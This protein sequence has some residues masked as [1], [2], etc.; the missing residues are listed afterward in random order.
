MARNN[1]KIAT[2]TSQLFST[3]WLVAAGAQGSSGGGGYMGEPFVSFVAT[4]SQTG[5]VK[6]APDAAGTIGTTAA[7]NGRFVGIAKSDSTQTAALAGVVYVWSPLPQVLYYGSPKSAAAFDTQAEI[8]ALKGAA[9][10]FDLS[11]ATSGTYTIDTAAT[12]AS[13]NA[14]VI[15]DGNLNSGQVFFV[16]KPGWSYLGNIS[17]L[18]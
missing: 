9:V 12:D 17:T 2:P 6:V 18:S 7:T 11:A 10:I 4:A 3:K 15:V 5:I 13:A 16:V 1:I 14:L 8:D